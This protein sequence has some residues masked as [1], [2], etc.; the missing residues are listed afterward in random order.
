MASEKGSL[1]AQVWSFPG[2]SEVEFMTIS[3]L[4]AMAGIDLAGEYMKALDVE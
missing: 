4:Q 2:A 3:A 1:L